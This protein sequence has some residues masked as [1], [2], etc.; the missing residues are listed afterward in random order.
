MIWKTWK[1]SMLVIITHKG[2]SSSSYLRPPTPAAVAAAVIN[3][4]PRAAAAA[5]A[6][7]LTFHPKHTTNKNKTN[8]IMKISHINVNIYGNY[9]RKVS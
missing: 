2:S 8:H 9:G 5:A 3:T 4:Y 1:M 7:S 6:I